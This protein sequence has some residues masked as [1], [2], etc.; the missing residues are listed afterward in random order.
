MERGGAWRRV[1]RRSTF[2]RVVPVAAPCAMTLYRTVPAS[3]APGAEALTVAGVVAADGSEVSFTVPAAG[4]QA[5]DAGRYQYR[6]TV[7][8]VLMGT[9]VLLRGYVTVHDGVEG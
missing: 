3:T 8:D 1:V 4:T 5:L 9:L 6:I 7:T 2:D